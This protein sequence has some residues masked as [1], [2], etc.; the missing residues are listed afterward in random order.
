VLYPL[1]N[2]YLRKVLLICMSM[3]KNIKGGGLIRA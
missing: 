2:K 3:D 1:L